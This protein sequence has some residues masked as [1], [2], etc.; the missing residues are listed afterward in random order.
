MKLVDIDKVTYRKHANI[1]IGCIIVSLAVISLV[2][3]YSLI[4]FCGQTPVAGAESTSNFKFNL[5]GVI[6]AALICA[7]ILYTLRDHAFLSEVYYIWQLKQLNNKIYRKLRKVKAAAESNDENA[8]ACLLFYYT[9]LKQVYLL[10]DNTL[11]MSSLQRDL[12]QLTQKM[13]LLKPGLTTED[14]SP[15]WLKS[16][17]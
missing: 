13:S 16:L 11:T 10:D 4:A 14:F 5:A 12:D 7:S 8:L 15:E 6:A 1:V 2:V 3:S 17:N 9:A